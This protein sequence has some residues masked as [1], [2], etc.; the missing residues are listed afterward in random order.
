MKP[1]IIPCKCHHPYQ[2]EKYGYQHR[3]YNAML[4]KGKVVGYRCTVC[5]NVKKEEKYVQT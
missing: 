5:S 1:K 3:V 2:D 4:A